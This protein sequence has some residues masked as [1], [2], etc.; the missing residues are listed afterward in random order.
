VTTPRGELQIMTPASY[1]D[2]FAQEPPDV[3][4]GAR[5]AAIRFAVRDLGAAERTIADSGTPLQN[6]MGRIVVGPA[7]ARGATLVFEVA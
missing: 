2:H 6:H 1:R 4:A 7:A 5:L 3:G